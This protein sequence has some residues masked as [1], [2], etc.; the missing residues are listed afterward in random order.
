M[1]GLAPWPESFFVILN[2]AW[3]TA[4]LASAVLIPRGGLVTRTACWFL[5]LAALLNAI[6]HPLLAL[7]VG[8]YFPGLWTSPLLGAAGYALWRVLRFAKAD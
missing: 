1:L 3:L 6:A 4:W 7:S 8:G 5:T 2:V